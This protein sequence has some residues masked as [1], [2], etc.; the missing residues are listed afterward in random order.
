M[1]NSKFDKKPYLLYFLSPALQNI[2]VSMCTSMSDVET[3][4]RAAKAGCRN[5]VVKPIKA[6]QL[7]QRVRE[8]LHN[9]KEILKDKS[10]ILDELGIDN[11][12][13]DELRL[14]FKALV[15]DVIAVLQKSKNEEPSADD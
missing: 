10:K 2:P 6:A 8:S 12:T 5:Y 3:V 14:S 7:I 15:E 9:E 1:T 11:E 13:Y 4:R